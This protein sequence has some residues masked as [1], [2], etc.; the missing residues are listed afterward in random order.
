MLKIL[1]MESYPRIKNSLKIKNVA[2]LR[3]ETFA[4]KKFRE[5]RKITKFE[6]FHEKLTISKSV[7]IFIKLAFEVHFV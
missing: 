3:G 4:G 6:A 7:S 1:I 5:V 2:T